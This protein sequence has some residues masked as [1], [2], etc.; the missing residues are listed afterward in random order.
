MVDFVFVRRNQVLVIAVDNAEEI[1]M[2][3]ADLQ[4]VAEIESKPEFFGNLFH[5]VFG[6]GY[7]AV[8]EM[9]VAG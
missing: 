7:H 4:N 8:G 3:F 2:V 6:N 5:V 9:K 1:A